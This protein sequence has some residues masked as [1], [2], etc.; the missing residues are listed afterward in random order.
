MKKAIMT[1]FM[2]M[3][4]VLGLLVGCTGVL[5]GSGDLKTVEYTLQDFTGVDIGSAF[6]FNIRQSNSYVISITADD[7]I[8][9][10]IEVNAMSHITG[11]GLLENIPRV[12]PDDAC[13]VINKNSWQ[14][15]AVFD[16]LQEK[17]PPDAE[18]DL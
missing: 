14:R 10:K 8:L 1:V 9:E 5:T 2:L 4:F 11:G 13:A 18:Q 6:E 3:P 7:N 12:M 15:P 17:G 16:W